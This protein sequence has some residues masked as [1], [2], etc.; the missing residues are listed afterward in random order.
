LLAALE[1]SELRV[2][3]VIELMPAT[4]SRTGKEHF[5][6]SAITRRLSLRLFTRPAFK[7]LEDEK[8]KNEKREA[9]KAFPTPQILPA[10]IGPYVFY[11]PYIKNE[12][13]HHDTQGCLC[14][15]VP[16]THFGQP[17]TMIKTYIS[18]LFG[19]PT[20]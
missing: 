6:R 11:L 18:A 20:F 14:T 13:A 1:G 10:D 8:G 4:I 17:Q 7:N 19:M 9:E 2:F 16:K 12:G 3:L 15:V 5:R